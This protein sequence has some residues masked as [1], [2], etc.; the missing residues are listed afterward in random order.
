MSEI[1]RLFDKLFLLLKREREIKNTALAIE[2]MSVFIFLRYLQVNVLRENRHIEIYT[3][4]KKDFIL[5]CHNVVRNSRFD[6]H[7]LRNN[8]SVEELLLNS[9]DSFILKVDNNQVFYLLSEFLNNINN[10]FDL[11]LLGGVYSG[12]IEKMVLESS[13]SGEFYTP[14]VI[15]EVVVS[16]LKPN[17]SDDIYDPAC[18]TSGF[19]VEAN[20]YI[21]VNDVY[22]SCSYT[23][24]GNDI[25]FFAFIVSSV[26]LIINSGIKSNIR[27]TDSL[28]ISESKYNS[29]SNEFYN[30]VLTNPP[31]G[32]NNK[33]CFNGFEPEQFVDYKFLRH[34]MHS[35][36]V[37][38]RAAVILPERFIYD[39][40]AQSKHLKSELFNQ[41]NVECIL[42]LPSGVM[43]PYTGVKLFIIF[44]S[45]TRSN[46]N[47]WLYK[48]NKTEKL[49]KNKK[50]QISDF[51]D[52]FKKEKVKEESENSWL[53]SIDEI[54]SDYNV[55][56]RATANTN[57]NDFDSFFESLSGIDSIGSEISDKINSISNKIRSIQ[58]SISNANKTYKYTKVK[59]GELVTSLKTVPLAAGKLIDEGRYEVYGGNGVIGYYDD[60]I[61][62]GEFIIVGRV[63]GLCGNVHYVEGDIWVTNN[64]I[65]LKCIDLD[66]VYPPYLARLLSNKDLRG[67]ASGTAQPHLTV[68][69]VKNIDVK[70]PPLKV[71]VELEEWL[72]Q[73]DKE[74]TLQNELVKQ[75][76]SRGE[77]LINGLNSHLLQI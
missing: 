56:E 30:I 20:K 69:K 58:F 53:I 35:L 72:S 67:L 54:G 61:H 39:T 32:K 2:F 43:L 17:C 11:K 29:N 49:T 77:S 51:D 9:L 24:N 50:L 71:Q 55:L 63:G 22:N 13:Q 21:K 14:K 64:S 42:S 76:S 75:L 52:F 1:K 10:D 25:S 41:F 31:F 40:S 23:L 73:L 45:R 6:C 59:V 18:G 5:D 66:R 16:Y 38:G 74:L 7:L 15:S 68:T 62:S 4:N 70:L 34:V 46:G 37:D 65:V 8:P 3:S 60:F 33:D 48:L 26:N 12:L 57:F 19:L 44:F 47:V 27:L 36:R 28:K